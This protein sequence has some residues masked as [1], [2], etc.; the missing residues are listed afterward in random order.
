MIKGFLFGFLGIICG[1]LFLVLLIYLFIRGLLNKYGFAGMSLKSIYKQ[2][3]ESERA[4]K[5]RHKQVSGM[6]K[7]LLP[8]IQ[9]NF[10]DFN[11]KE[12]YVLVEKCLRAIFNALEHED[13]SYLNDDDFRIIKEKI[14]NQI[15]DLQSNNITYRYDDIIFHNHAIKSYRY[16]NDIA[17][18]EISTSLE[19]YYS[20]RKDN[21]DISHDD[22]KKQTRYTTTFVYI[23]DSTKAGFDI[24]VLGLHCPNCGSPITSLQQQKCSYCGGAINIQVAN[25]LKCWKIINYKEDY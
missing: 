19:Y 7:I 22:V 14:Q 9:R 12:I 24:D 21:K 4:E 1:I 5:L 13:I 20:K 11:E 17:T 8:E 15:N 16:E 6:T 25:L 18:L 2:A 10:K 3:K 23:V